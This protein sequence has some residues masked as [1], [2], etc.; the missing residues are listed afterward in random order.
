[1]DY[2]GLLE[3]RVRGTVCRI[4]PIMNKGLEIP[5][6]LIVKKGSTNSEVFRKIKHF[7]EEYYIEP[8]L[9]KKPEV[10]EADEL[11]DD[12]ISDKFIPVE[13]GEETNTVEV[14]EPNDDNETNTVVEADERNDD[15]RMNATVVDER[16]NG[17]E[18]ER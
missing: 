4:L 12:E 7:S 5:V 10:E 13:D 3:A 2:G 14:S 8:D 18:K 17:N 16:N 11:N 9:I 6:T 1:M 15:D